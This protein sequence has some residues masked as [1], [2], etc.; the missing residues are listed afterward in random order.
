M[1]SK[2]RRTNDESETPIALAHLFAEL[3]RAAQGAN[4]ALHLY[5]KQ[6][7]SLKTYDA[8]WQRLPTKLRVALPVIANS[9][10]HG[11]LEPCNEYMSGCM[12]LS[13]GANKQTGIPFATLAETLWHVGLVTHVNVL[14]VDPSRITHESP[15]T[16]HDAGWDVLCPYLAAATANHEDATTP[17][18]IDECCHIIAIECAEECGVRLDVF[19]LRD[20]V[21]P[22]T[23]V[24]EPSRFLAWTVLRSSL[25][26]TLI[27]TFLTG[28]LRA[29]LHRK[30]F[31]L[32]FD[33]Q[34]PNS[35][36]IISS[37]AQELAQ[38]KQ[39]MHAM[40]TSLARAHNDVFEMGPEDELGNSVCIVRNKHVKPSAHRYSD[41]TEALKTQ[42]LQ[43]AVDNNIAFR[44]VPSS[45]VDAE[46]VLQKYK[47]CAVD[48]A[49]SK[50]S[51][52]GYGSRPTLDRHA[53]LVDDAL[54]LLL[55]DKVAKDAC[56]VSCLRQAMRLQEH[57]C[58]KT[59]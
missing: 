58:C 38:T 44:N 50:P 5:A 27:G 30:H 41:H 47:G 2:R 12:Q 4:R 59:A 56:A 15:K 48:D 22:L 36:D 39:Q 25:M 9:F 37:L 29:R 54:D 52:I 18:S 14:L 33:L 7:A 10:M 19:M 13:H 34:L 23:A 16:L 3:T 17:I 45:L 49:G 51:S 21:A 35:D 46:R 20:L 8:L 28:H 26:P 6:T 1:S 24:T 55:K 32:S 42:M 31:D 11:V 57:I 43:Y 40:T 53:L